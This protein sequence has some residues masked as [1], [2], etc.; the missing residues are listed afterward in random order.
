MTPIDYPDPV[1]RRM[2]T[3]SLMSAVIMNALDTTIAN[4]ALPHM[5][6]SVSASQDEITWV[7]TSYIVA[8]AIMTPLSGWLANRFGRKPVMLCSVGAFMV[9]SALC[10]IATGL[11]ELVLFRF[12]QGLAG[13]AL[14]PISQ[15]ILFE[16]NPPEK[17][18]QAM[19]IFGMGAVLGPIIGPV[20]GGWLTDNFSWRWCFYINVPVGAATLFGIATFF[21]EKPPE[22]R[23]RFDAFGFAMLALSVGLFQLVLDR[24]QQQDWFNSTEIC[25]E[26]GLAIFFIFSF[27]V[28]M[29]T[30]AE[31]FIDL[32]LFKDLNYSFSLFFSFLVGIGLFGVSALLPTMLQHL[33]GYPVMLTGMMMAPRGVGSMVGMAGVGWLMRYFDVRILIMTGFA[34]VAYAVYVLAGITLQMDSRLVMWSGFLNGLGNGLAFVPLSTIAFSTLSTKLRNEAS[35]M[36]TLIRSLGSAV[37]ISVLSVMTYRSGAAVHSR[38][39][40]G[41]RPDNPMLDLRAPGFDFSDPSAV[42]QM[43]GQIDLQAGMVSYVDSY[44]AL[45][46]VIA[47]VTPLVMLMRPPRGGI[48]G[49]A[50]PPAHMD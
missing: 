32:S 50:A 28:Q 27:F 46:L 5:Q 21:K 44:Y 42:A 49:A 33:M 48:G 26:T 45:A 37:G 17:H 20:V 14:V 3:I 6:G 31:P 1:T 41:V 15:A 38:L 11:E 13:S 34:L 43:A 23:M 10:G 39:A 12:L 30:A 7:L 24:G 29:K 47:L 2:V 16:I 22:G 35:A 8:S 18:G 40:E 36:F 4:V 9:T 19:A 25:I